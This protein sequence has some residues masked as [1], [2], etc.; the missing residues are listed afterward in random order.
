[1]RM[2]DCHP[3]RVHAANGLC[4][5][6]YMRSRRG[7]ASPRAIGRTLRRN[8]Q[9]RN[10]RVCA[11]CQKRFAVQNM[12][13]RY[14]S[15]MCR[16]QAEAQRRRVRRLALR[17]PKPPRQP[18]PPRLC[19]VCG[20]SLRGTKR[21]RYCS[22][23]CCDQARHAVE[24]SCRRCGCRGVTVPLVAIPQDAGGGWLCKLCLVEGLRRAA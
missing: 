5:M 13:C 15:D 2:A 17:P 7:A 20:A 22:A 9:H 11:H 6:C 1:M 8:H 16:R 12:K 3:D 10:D 18:V 21:T 23:W 24:R 14:C 4:P 19:V